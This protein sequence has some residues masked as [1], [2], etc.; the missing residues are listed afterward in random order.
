MRVSRSLGGALALALVSHFASAAPVQHDAASPSAT[1]PGIRLAQSPSPTPA[2]AQGA[3]TGSA[4]MNA[5][6]G[7]TLVLSESGKPE[8]QIA[9][10][11][12]ADGT[13]KG[14]AG[15]RSRTG[16]WTVSGTKLCIADENKEPRPQDCAELTVEGE[17][18]TLTT[19]H[20]GGKT[21][22]LRGQILKGNPRNM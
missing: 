9:L 5:L 17:G 20:S 4:A 7:N 2:P 15:N 1:T 8:E 10:Y 13:V 21:N 16:K 6:V 11:F 12:L 19:T 14:A 3:L 22:A 18:V